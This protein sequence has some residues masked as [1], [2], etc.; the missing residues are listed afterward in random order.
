M[1]TT[2]YPNFIKGIEAVKQKLLNTGK[3]L[4]QKTWQAIEVVGTEK[5]IMF[6]AL[7]IFLQVQIPEKELW[8][9]QIK[10]NLPW[11]DL[12][13]EERVGGLPL[14]PPPSHKVWPFAQKNNAEFGGEEKFSHTYPERL[15]PKFAGNPGE[16]HKLYKQGTAG[17]PQRKGIR[18]EYGDLNDI[19]N[20]LL[21]DS[22]TRQAFLPLWFPEDTGATHKQRVPCTIGYHFIR[23]HGFLHIT[24]WIRS[25]DFFRHFR[26]DIYLAVKLA[27]WVLNL[28]KEKDPNNWGNV[29]LG[30]YTMHIVNLHIFDQEKV[31][32]KQ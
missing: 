4:H 26:D 7:N 20:L 8:V 2:I 18:Y 19:I 14:N 10:P 31:M 15:W 27:D 3:P 17:N 13:F 22:L 28:L 1:V 30:L 11:A 29:K 5:E 24:Y 32:L 6:E 21:D 23:R 25:C 16:E 12:H 9:E